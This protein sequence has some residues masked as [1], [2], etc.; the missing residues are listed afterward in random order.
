MLFKLLHII[1]NYPS[2]FRDSHTQTNVLSNDIDVGNCKPI[3]PQA[4]RVHP[5]KRV[6]MQ[7]EVTYLLERGFA[8]PSSNPSL[9]VPKSDQTPWFL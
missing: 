5:S 7:R 3:K 1:T 6:F 9:L 8:V 2:I 4:Y